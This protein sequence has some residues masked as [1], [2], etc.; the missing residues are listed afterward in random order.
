MPTA[1]ADTP[2]V[3]EA[4]SINAPSPALP[5]SQPRAPDI[6]AAGSRVA[7]RNE[8]TGIGEVPSTRLHA[9]PGG[10]STFRLGFDV[11]ETSADRVALLKQRRAA[12]MAMAR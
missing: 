10:H 1:L 2:A 6:A 7:V 12:S 5:Q 3:P 8:H 4:A 11:P 9:A